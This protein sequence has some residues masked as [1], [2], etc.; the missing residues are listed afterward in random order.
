MGLTAGATVRVRSTRLVSFVQRTIAAILYEVEP[1]DGPLRVVVQSELVANEPAPP[2]SADPR[3][4]AALESPLHSEE[5]SHNDARVVLVHSTKHSGLR[6]AAGMDHV[7]E[8]PEE[9][10]RA[11]SA[12]EVGRMTVAANVGVGQRVRVVKFIAY[13]WSSQRSLPAVRDLVVAALAEARH[14]GWDGLVA[15]QREYLDDFWDRADVE[16]DGDTEL[17]RLFALRCS[18]PSRPGRARNGERSRPRA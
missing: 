8:G 17:S 16:L 12:S 11:P 15:L 18:T 2:Q 5:F 6:V 13:G 9:P 10:S 14:T 4:A 7:V 3:A 1:V